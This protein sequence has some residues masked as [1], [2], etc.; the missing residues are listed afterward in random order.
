[1]IISSTLVDPSETAAN[2]HILPS[3]KSP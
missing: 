3:L 1:M 2:F